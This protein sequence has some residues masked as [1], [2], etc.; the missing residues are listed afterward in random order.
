MSM[1]G[2]PRDWSAVLF[3]LRTK[4]V[5]LTRAIDFVAHPTGFGVSHTGSAFGPSAFGAIGL[6]RA[7]VREPG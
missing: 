4:I 5:E 6:L 3:S 7:R 2:Q 1:G